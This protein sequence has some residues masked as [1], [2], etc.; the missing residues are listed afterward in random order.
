M[1]RILI[2][3]AL[4]A[5]ALNSAQAKSYPL[6]YSVN[7]IDFTEVAHDGENDELRATIGGS[8][9]TTTFNRSRGVSD[10]VA[11]TARGYVRFGKFFISPPDMAL[12]KVASG[13]FALELDVEA[14]FS[15]HRV[16]IS[17]STRSCT[18]L[19]PHGLT[20]PSINE[21]QIPKFAVAGSQAVTLLVTKLKAGSQT[22]E[23]VPGRVSLK[24]CKV[25]WGAAIARSGFDYALGSNGT[26]FWLSSG[27]ALTLKY[28]NNGT[29]WK[30]IELPK[31][32]HALLSTHASADGRMWVL[33]SRAD[34][35]FRMSIYSAPIGTA[36]WRE[37]DIKRD[38]PPQNWIEAFREIAAEA[39]QNK[40]IDSRD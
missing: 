12:R 31:T 35:E 25:V 34:Q 16:Q 10:V 7:G 14:D 1:K 29:V 18:V 2:P 5:L 23:L 36:H 33:V 9:L 21:G 38:P 3:L 19:A 26:S 22:D 40:V 39:A 32:T 28:S 11:V 8:E 6:K 15:P 37:L 30:H 24:D 20:F 13:R 4:V 17:T 27:S